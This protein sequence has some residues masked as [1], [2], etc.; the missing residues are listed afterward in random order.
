MA[1]R[2]IEPRSKPSEARAPLR[3]VRLGSPDIIVE[4][5]ADGAILMRSPHP[6]PEHAD[7]LTA[8]LDFWSHAAAERIFLAQRDRQGEWRV[9][10]YART[11]A[12]VYALAAALVQ[13]DLSPER[14][15]A[16]LSGNSISHALLA[17][18]AM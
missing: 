8:R 3:P 4:R 11:R 6:V 5:G 14:P 17:L 16:I 15:I 12:R 10:T 13:R 7:T 18:A 9:L 1:E 2:I